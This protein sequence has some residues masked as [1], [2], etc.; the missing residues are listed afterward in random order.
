MKNLDS[1]SETKFCPNEEEEGVDCQNNQNSGGINSS[2]I[3]ETIRKQSVKNL[4]SDEENI[5]IVTQ[6]RISPDLVINSSQEYEIQAMTFEGSKQNLISIRDLDINIYSE[7]QPPS[8]RTTVHPPAILNVGVSP[9]SKVNKPQNL[10]QVVQPK[11][12]IDEEE[13]EDNKMMENVVD[14]ESDVVFS[15][16]LSKDR[17]K[18]DILVDDQQEEL[19]N[20][21]RKIPNT[22]T[23]QKNQ[24]V[25][26]PASKN[27]NEVLV[28][29]SD[30]NFIQQQQ[31]IVD[32]IVSNINNQQQKGNSTINNKNFIN[33]KQIQDSLDNLKKSQLLYLQSQ[34]QM[35]GSNYDN[36]VKVYTQQKQQVSFQDEQKQQF[37]D[38]LRRPN[39]SVH[40]SHHKSLDLNDHIAS[41][42][43][44]NSSTNGLTYKTVSLSKSFT[45]S[46]E[47]QTAGGYN[48]T[49]IMNPLSPDYSKFLQ[50]N[51]QSVNYTPMSFRDNTEDKPL[52]QLNQYQPINDQISKNQSILQ[53]LVEANQMQYINSLEMKVTILQQEIINL[54]QLQNF[55]QTNQLPH[56]QDSITTSENS[57]LKQIVERQKNRITELEAQV[58]ILQSDKEQMQTDIS[59]L[60][61][62]Q[63]IHEQIIQSLQLRVDQIASQ[64]LHETDIRLNMYKLHDSNQ[65]LSNGLRITNR[66]PQLRNQ[67][68][69]I[70]TDGLMSYQSHSVPRAIKDQYNQNNT[71]AGYIRSG[72]LNY[73]QLVDPYQELSS[74]DRTRL[75]RFSE[76]SHYDQLKDPSKYLSNTINKQILPYNPIQTQHSQLYQKEADE[77]Y[78]Y[79]TN[80]APSYNKPNLHVKSTNIRPLTNEVNSP[81]IT[82]KRGSARS[83][84]SPGVSQ[85]MKWEKNNEDS[86]SPT[87]VE[88]EE[89][90]DEE[91]ITLRGRK[92]VFKQQQSQDYR[93]N[94]RN[95]FRNN[96]QSNRMIQSMVINHHDMSNYMDEDEDNLNQLNSST[97]MGVIKH[98]SMK[99]KDKKRSL[100]N[101][102]DIINPNYFSAMKGKTQIQSDA[103]SDYLREQQDDD[104]LMQSPYEDQDPNQDG[105]LM[106]LQMEKDKLEREYSKYLGQQKRQK[107][108]EQ[109]QNLE[110]K[111]EEL[112]K[113]I[114]KIKIRNRQKSNKR[115]S[116]IRV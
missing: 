110:V 114:S 87:R 38:S 76:K 4:F 78:N 41:K 32:Q 28:S 112:N 30:D 80:N 18:D 24:Y 100:I 58:K 98:G 53:N 10:N 94:I 109:K 104:M 3:N 59:E 71:N 52:E 19:L 97:Q 49:L 62:Q 74:Q 106:Q 25:Y 56:S 81:L 105:K 95:S 44:H 8:P 31:Q 34:N 79:M 2:F 72:T 16:N 92:G 45:C 54:Q 57:Y 33:S 70:E 48:D 73:E 6:H 75:P 22:I 67:G 68:G 102:S 23:K 89:F 115:R 103:R 7:N 14:S 111:I 96:E 36:M 88:A 113:Q 43:T 86:Q 11:Q 21:V 91:C 1:S 90:Q 55:R 77:N 42:N 101:N 29:M 47:K 107:S 37:D 65:L 5:K 51:I 60:K 116:T 39:Y 17:S 99:I 83:N 50:N 64:M 66:S 12:Q 93:K 35:N 85:I 13:D 15:G 9:Q 46:P 61:S 63:R 108:R 20:S 82:M 26:N 40:H 84:K 27:K 69:F